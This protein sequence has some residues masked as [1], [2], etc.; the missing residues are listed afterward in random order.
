MSDSLSEC[1]MDTMTSTIKVTAEIV[2]SYIPI[3]AT[4]K[5]L[6][7][8]IYKIYSNV[9]CNKELCLIMM[10]RVKTAE[11]ALEQMM[12]KSEENKEYFYENEYSL[13]LNKFVNVLKDIKNFVEKVSKIEGVRKFFE[14]NRIKQT[15]EKLTQEFDTCMKE[16]H[17]TIAIANKNQRAKDAQKVDQAIEK[18]EK[19]NLGID[20]KLSIIMSKM[21]IQ[22]GDVP[23]INENDWKKPSAGLHKKDSVIR[24]YYNG[25]EVA[26][27]P[28][29]DSSQ[30]KAERE[31]LKELYEKYDI[32][33][34]RKIQI[35]RD[36]CNGLIFLREIN[37]LHHDISTTSFSIQNQLEM[38]HWM[39]PKQIEKYKKYSNKKSYTFS[40]EMFSFRMLIWELCY[41]R[42]PY[43]PLETEKVADYVLSG[44]R[45]KLTSRKFD[46]ANDVNIQKKFNEI[47]NKGNRIDLMQLHS[48]LEKLAEHNPIA[49]CAPQ[50]LE[51]NK[52]DFGDTENSKLPKFED[53][54]I[55]FY[56][57]NS[58][59]DPLI[60]VD[61]GIK[62]HRNKNYESAWKCFEKN[63]KLCNPLEQYWQAY[64]LYYGYF[65]KQDKEPVADAQYR[66]AV[67]LINNFSNYPNINDEKRN[68]ILHY[69]KLASNNKNNKAAYQL[70]NIYVNGA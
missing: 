46:N 30:N 43:K 34:N 53:E 58:S 23:N 68:K 26:C 62:F 21:N 61:E 44:K 19:L 24:K 31:N 9:E 4:I 52:L 17:F 54:P 37:I 10:D 7:E 57:N 66:Y 51:N 25:I 14:A 22:P 18:L 1:V 29:E 5:I 41:E 45:E 63:F 70:G 27:K 67:S 32:P 12:L 6:V 35:I 3:V 38:F 8:E 50:L 56:E 33:W 28:I 15:Y 60:S 39:A 65:V 36:I 59:I 40:C 48:E 11:F 42:I 2:S 64:Y 55:N 20:N 13:S 16:L 49:L 69:L 47:I